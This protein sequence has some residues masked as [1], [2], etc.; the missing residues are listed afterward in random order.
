MATTASQKRPSK[1]LIAALILLLVI[2]LLGIFR[3]SVAISAIEYFSK[4][5]DLSI[6][7]LDFSLDWALTLNIHQLCIDSPSGTLKLQQATWRPWSNNLDIDL[8]QLEHLESA[9]LPTNNNH[10]PST[11]QQPKKL[12]LPGYLPRL[13]ISEIQVSSYHLQQ[14]IHLSLAQANSNQL[15]IGGDI[16]A[17]ITLSPDLISVDI[18]WRLAD[19][20]TW[21]P[22]VQ[23]FLEEYKTILQEDALDKAVIAS[24]IQ[25][26]GYN[27]EASNQIDINSRINLENCPIDAVIAGKIQLDADI[28]KLSANLDM[29]Q[30]KNTVNLDSCLIIKDYLVTSNIPELALQVPQKLTF[31]NNQLIMPTL[32]LIDNKHPERIVAFENVSV[33]ADK[34]IELAYQFSIKQLLL[35]KLTQQGQLN[36]EGSGELLANISSTPIS[37][38]FNQQEHHLHLE[39][40]K[41]DPLSIENINSNFEI[42]GENI[43]Q[44]KFKIESQFAKL[45]LPE[46]EIENISN[47]LEINLVDLNLITFK[48]S[49][50]ITDIAVQDIH[51]QPVEVQHQGEANW[52]KS[53]VSS[54]HNLT[55]ENNVAL[56]L[57]QQ[58]NQMIATFEQQDIKFLQPLINQV[59]NAAVVKTGMFSADIELILPLENEPLSATG[60]V[61]VEGL[62]AKYGN[63]VF[64]NLN[65]QSPLMF[66]SAGLQIPESTLRI[67]SINLGVNVE[68]IQAKVT[69]KDNA[70]RLLDIQGEILNGQFQLDELW[71]DGREQQLTIS[72]LELDLAQLVALQ[73]QP[74]IMITGNIDGDLPLT[75]NKQ[76]VRIED[77]WVSSLLGGKLTIADNPSFNSIREQQPQLA[78]LENLDFSQLES[79]VT[80]DP[81]GEMLFDFAI[82]GVNTKENQAVNFNYSHQENIFSLL[83]SIRLINSVENAIEQKINQGDKK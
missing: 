26:D 59:D 30:L 9:A 14:P 46:V 72:I 51:A 24:Q 67:D 11:M 50:K 71:L 45:E 69:A 70:V 37:F 6:S 65:Y 75:M 7:C 31:E 40:I 61:T 77:G 78:L 68:Q 44:L 17:S 73:Q 54:E 1:K 8:L 16:E 74:G 13:N 29:S 25:F 63:Y 10:E 79:N 83:E 60:A 52:R 53:T 43:E 57:V 76:G 28:N 5:A 22:Q 27:I 55:L 19:L 42:V 80:L 12:A 41:V 36:F 15:K 81:D 23:A 32:H 21:L 82:K 35:S 62:S 3:R 20:K 33:K 39:N 66:D 34:E 56:N 49:S 47:Q 64:N 2:L 4:P 58:Q 38:I 48:G 18:E